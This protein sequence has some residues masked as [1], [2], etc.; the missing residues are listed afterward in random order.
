[1][2]NNFQQTVTRDWI[3]F[4]FLVIINPDLDDKSNFKIASQKCRIKPESLIY[5]FG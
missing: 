5:L 4:F 1:M 2:K 3:N